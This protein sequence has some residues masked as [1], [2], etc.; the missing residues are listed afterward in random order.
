[1][2]CKYCG[3]DCAA[4]GSHLKNS[5]KI[6]DLKEYYDTFIRRENE[7]ICLVCGK[8]TAFRGLTKGY[9]TYC[10]GKCSNAAKE[11]IDKK[12]HT[13]K[14]RHGDENYRNVEQSRI[15][16]L[17][18]YGQFNSE[19]CIKKISATKQGKTVE[20]IAEATE[21]SRLTRDSKW[22]QWRAPDT[23]AKI[24]NTKLQKYG[25]ATYN[26]RMRCH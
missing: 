3:K 20:E 26:N 14:E 18:L 9:L 8:E 19:E 12:K 6:T 5:H 15:T 4:L 22:C 23:T 24:A 7:G 25:S 16:R 11:V 2:I 1:M 10:S 17:A 21:K 13:T